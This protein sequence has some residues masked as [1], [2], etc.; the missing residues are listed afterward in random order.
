M[1]RLNFTPN[2]KMPILAHDV[3]KHKFD[4]ILI[5]EAGLL[6]KDLMG[7]TGYKAVKLPRK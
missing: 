7:M 2:N 6:K 4:V 1:C 3:G 5:S